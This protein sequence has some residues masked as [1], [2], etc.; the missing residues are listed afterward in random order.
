P[1]TATVIFNFVAASVYITFFLFGGVTCNGGMVR[2]VTSFIRSGTL[3]FLTISSPSRSYDNLKVAIVIG[4]GFTHYVAIFIFDGNSAS[5]LCSPRNSGTFY[6]AVIIKIVGDIFYIRCFWCGGVTCNG[7]RVRLVTSF[8]G[9]GYLIFLTICSPAAF[10][11][12]LK[13][14]IVIGCGFTHYVAIFIFD[15]NSASSLFPSTTRFP[16]YVAVIIKI[17]GDIFYIRCFWCGGV[18]CNGGRVRLVTSFIG[19]GYLIF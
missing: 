3:T 14:A 2:L 4:C 6:V 8:I 19:S 18:T 5:W 17:V 12:T 16:S 9:S 10:Y 7:G 1:Y 13:V 11:D 15:G